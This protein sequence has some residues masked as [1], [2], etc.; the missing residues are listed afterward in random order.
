MKAIFLGRMTID[1]GFIPYKARIGSPHIRTFF[2]LCLALRVR[3][4]A[5]VSMRSVC[6]GAYARLYA[7]V[8]ACAW[9]G[10]PA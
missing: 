7:L 8:R 4:P 5:L 3:A 9:Y 1:A 6:S 10:G 2:G